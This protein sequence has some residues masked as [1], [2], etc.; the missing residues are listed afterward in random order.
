VAH[1]RHTREHEATRAIIDE[2]PLPVFVQVRVECSRIF[3]K[4]N[5]VHRRQVG[6]STAGAEQ[7][8]PQLA[9]AGEEGF[10]TTGDLVVADGEQPAVDRFTDVM[11]EP[12][13]HRLVQDL[14]LRIPEC[15]RLPLDAVVYGLACSRVVFPSAICPESAAFPMPEAHMLSTIMFAT[16]VFSERCLDAI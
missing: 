15:V 7:R 10:T 2:G 14:A 13:E 1:E 3:G 5:P 4:A 6:G 9:V 12:G 16:D 8:S 11:L